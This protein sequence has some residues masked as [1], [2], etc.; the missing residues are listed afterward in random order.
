MYLKV[1]AERSQEEMELMAQRREV[2]IK[3][4]QLPWNPKLNKVPTCF[5]FYLS[6]KIEVDLIDIIMQLLDVQFPKML[7]LGFKAVSKRATVN[8]RIYNA[9]ICNKMAPTAPHEE[10]HLYIPNA[11]VGR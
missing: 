4:T 7:F 6:R 8:T 3:V 11:Q 10:G 9:A 2:N 5:F 1:K